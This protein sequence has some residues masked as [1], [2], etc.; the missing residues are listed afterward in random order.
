MHSLLASLARLP[1]TLPE[2]RCLL[3]EPAALDALF[4]ARRG[5]SGGAGWQL[6]G[7][8]WRPPRLP[9]Q[10]KPAAEQADA[11]QQLREAGVEVSELLHTEELPAL[12]DEQ[13]V[14]AGGGG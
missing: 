6:V 2:L 4:E 14:A 12:L 8:R 3:L 9:G 1:S 11:V 10:A 5:A 13:A 7:G